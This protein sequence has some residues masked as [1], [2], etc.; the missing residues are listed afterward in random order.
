[1]RFERAI[2]APGFGALRSVA[3]RLRCS[4]VRWVQGVSALLRRNS[5]MPPIK[6]AF[7]CPLTLPYPP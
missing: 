5:G 2:P 4:G 3:L 1:M 7:S 6:M